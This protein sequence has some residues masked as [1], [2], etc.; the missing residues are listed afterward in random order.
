MSSSRSRS[1]LIAAARLYYID[2]LSQE[3]AAAKL[4]MTRSNLSRVLK[5]AREE[6]VIEFRLND[7]GGR[8]GELEQ[9]LAALFALRGV[10]VAPSAPDRVPLPSVAQLAAAVLVDAL[11]GARVVAVSWGTA[12]RA[13]VEALSVT[14]RPDLRVVQLVGGLTSFDAHVS[15]HDLVRELGRRLSANYLYLNAPGVFDSR[16]ALQSLS[17]ERSISSTLE[18]AR[19]ADI[20]L[21]GIGNP[22]HGSSHVLLRQLAR[23]EQ[24]L[25][26]FWE[27]GPAGD[28]CGRYYDASGRP[29]EIEGISDRVLAIDIAGLMQIP[30]SIGVA[31]GTAKA[32]AVLGALR[33]KLVNTLVCDEPLAREMLA[34]QHD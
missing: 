27:A 25:R 28:V 20:A 9:E 13:V 8:V 30:V 11:E 6:G 34:R 1:T 24:Q 12:V 14:A 26:R 16:Q 18:L 23:S 21:V 19:Q 4:G 29:L 22:A 7:D 3:E 5:A 32:V 10:R 17:A 15:A 2:G 31:V 33:G